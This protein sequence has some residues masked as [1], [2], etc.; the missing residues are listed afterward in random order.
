MLIELIYRWTT[1][2]V[3]P[4]AGAAA[5]LRPRV[6]DGFRIQVTGPSPAAAGIHPFGEGQDMRSDDGQ[7][8][9]RQCLRTTAWRQPTLIVVAYKSLSLCIYILYPMVTA[10]GSLSACSHNSTRP[11][12]WHVP[13]PHGW[14]V[15][16]PHH[17]NRMGCWVTVPGLRLS[18]VNQ[19]VKFDNRHN[20]RGCMGCWKPDQA[21]SSIK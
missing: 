17:G 11:H 13:T 15:P 16:N 4:L 9:R 10:F 5:C 19:G 21:R 6:D 7:R 3:A 2:I 1:L 14:H 18:R 12:V 20:N 8:G